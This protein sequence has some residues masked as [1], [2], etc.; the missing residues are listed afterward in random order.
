MKRKRLGDALVEMGVVT[1]EQ[2]GV[3]LKKQKEAGKRLG[4]V[5]VELGMCSE[6]Q[7]VTVLSQ[8]L[9]IKIIQLE[10][11]E[12]PQEILKLIPETIIRNHILLPVFKLQNVLTVVM[13]D[14]L[15][16]FIIDEIHYQT[17]LTI[18]PAIAS[19]T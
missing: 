11:L 10:K 14:P 9:D 16:I 17:N 6:D 3:A 13:A 1:Q 19:E 2:I 4:K 12:I 15:D 7:I 8:Q 5:V 18:E